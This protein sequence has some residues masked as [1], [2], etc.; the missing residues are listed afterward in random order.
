MQ[1]EVTTEVAN[2]KGWV[3]GCLPCQMLTRWGSDG[4]L[5]GRKEP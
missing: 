4:T 5:A 1:V 2:P 3:E